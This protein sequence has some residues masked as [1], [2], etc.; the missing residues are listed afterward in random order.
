[1]AEGASSHTGISSGIPLMSP[2]SVTVSDHAGQP[3]TAQRGTRPAA[4]ATPGDGQVLLFLPRWQLLQQME[5]SLVL[6]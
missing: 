6:L 1:M 3:A 2:S 4:P 5:K